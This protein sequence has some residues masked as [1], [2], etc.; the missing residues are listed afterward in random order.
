M[1]VLV[2]WSN[3]NIVMDTLPVI[4]LTEW[5]GTPAR[6]TVYAYARMCASD[7]ALRLSMTAFDGEPPATQTAF[8]LLQLG[9]ARLRLAFTPDKTVRL[10]EETTGRRLPDPA[11]TFS[12]GVDEQGWYWQAAC[13]LEAAALAACGAALPRV[14]DSFRGGFFVQDALEEA[15]GS[16]F[17]AEHPDGPF[18][19]SAC[20]GS[21]AVISY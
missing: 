17:A 14:G 7:R 18:R 12:A 13:T 19:P 1:P 10:T 21:F 2:D 9:E 11:C 8:A 6:D 5:Y 4:K 20:L 15:F 16:A 3:Q